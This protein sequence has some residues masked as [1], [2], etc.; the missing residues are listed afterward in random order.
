MQDAERA[1]VHGWLPDLRSDDNDMDIREANFTKTSQQIEAGRQPAR[2][3]VLGP[4]QP[5]TNEGV[6]ISD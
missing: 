5:A 6:E 4:L 2:E 3:Q 1:F